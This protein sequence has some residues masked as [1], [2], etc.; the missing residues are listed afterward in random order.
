MNPHSAAQLI[1]RQVPQPL[2]LFPYLCVFFWNNNCTYLL[3]GLTFTRGFPCGSAGKECTCK[4]GDLGSIPGL[5]RSPG[6]N[7]N[8]L[9]YSCLENSMDCI[10]HRVA[11]TRTQLSDFHFTF[12]R[13]LL[14]AKHS[15]GVGGGVKV[16]ELLSLPPASLLAP[17]SPGKVLF[18]G[19]LSQPH[20][21][22]YCVILP[23][24]K[25]WLPGLRAGDGPWRGRKP[26]PSSSLGPQNLERSPS[27]EAAAPNSDLGL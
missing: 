22:L 1:F 5:G 6:G 20:C 11:K 13:G 18:L 21:P 23:L 10:V 25:S 24:E 26:K 19:N 15:L 9:Q 16:S 2:S 27:W 4:V 12:L 17:P 14:S 3:V 8:P 7:G